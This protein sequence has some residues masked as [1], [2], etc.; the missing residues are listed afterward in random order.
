MLKKL[1]SAQ[2][3]ETPEPTLDER[4]ASAAARASS[5]R[6]VFQVS[7]DELEGAAREQEHVAQD[8]Q[9]K[10]EELAEVAASAAFQA[11]ENRA[12]ADK[13]RALVA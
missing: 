4:A 3:T 13:L 12:A 9:A 8:A 6:S 11:A 1:L 5:A 2:P 7:I 10:I